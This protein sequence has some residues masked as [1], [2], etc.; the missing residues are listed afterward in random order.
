MVNVGSPVV[1]IVRTYT[2]KAPDL[3]ETSRRVETK[4]NGERRGEVD[5]HIPGGVAKVIILKRE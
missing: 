3:E 1:A 2:S 5:N 4:Q